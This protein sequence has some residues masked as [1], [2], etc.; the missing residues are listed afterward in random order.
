M[1]GRPTFLDPVDLLGE[2]APARLIAGLGVGFFGGVRVGE[3]VHVVVLLH[4]FEVFF[5]VLRLAVLVD[6]L[7]VSPSPLAFLLLA[8][9]EQAVSQQLA[10]P[11]VGL[12][13]SLVRLFGAGRGVAQGL[14]VLEVH[15]NRRGREGGRGRLA[16]G[17]PWLLLDRD[18]LVEQHVEQRAL[19]QLQLEARAGQ[20]VSRGPL[21]QHDRVLEDCGGLVRL[22]LFSLR[23]L[24]ALVRAGFGVLRERPPRGCARLDELLPL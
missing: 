15:A 6:R 24:V 21:V 16:P 7:Q 5:V 11:L 9:S 20:H 19:A 3:T 8:L 13:C 1:R 22:L 18:Q 10:A 23:A 17:Q 2:L 14:R 12:G 4:R